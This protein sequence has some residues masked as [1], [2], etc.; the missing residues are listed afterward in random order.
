MWQAQTKV[1]WV[2]SSQWLERVPRM[3]WNR[4]PASFALEE[5]RPGWWAQGNYTEGTFRYLS[6]PS[7]YIHIS[8]GKPC[9]RMEEQGSCSLWFPCVGWAPSALACSWQNA[10]TACYLLISSYKPTS[11]VEL[12]FLTSS[13]SGST[14]PLKKGK[15]PGIYFRRCVKCLFFPYKYPGVGHVMCTE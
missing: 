10:T 14:T 4:I 13:A 3:S 6:L 7:S 2:A 11:E 12:S 1:P 15:T 8:S 9:L 5:L